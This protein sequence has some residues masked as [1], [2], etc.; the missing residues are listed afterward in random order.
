[1]RKTVLAVAAAV[2]APALVRADDPPPQ[3]P[4]KQDEP[5]SAQPELERE[6]V[7]VASRREEPAANAT[8]AISTFDEED[9]DRLRPISV[10]DV[11]REAPGTYVSA[12]GP[13]GQF[14]RVFLRGAASNQTLLLV[15]GIPQNDATAG[16]LFDFG[17]LTMTGVERVEVLRGSYSVLYGSE[18]IGGV[19]SVHT[20]RG[21]GAPSGYVTAQI[22][23]FGTRREEV[24]WSTGDEDFDM[25]FAVGDTAS[26]GDIDREEY[27]AHDAV[28]RFGVALG[29]SMRFDGSLRI[30]CTSVQSPYDFASSGV[31]P[32][33]DNIGR[34]AETYSGGGTLTWDATRDLTVRATVSG[35]NVE[36][37][38]DNGPDG[39]VLVDP[40]LTPGTG[41]E[42]TAFRDEL[43]S[44]NTATDLR[45]RIEATA[46]LLRRARQRIGLSLTGGGEHLNQRTISSST[47]PNFTAPGST[48]TRLNDTTR[49][50]SLFAQA[51][52]RAPQDAVGGEVVSN[53]AVT[54]GY[55]GDDHSEFGHEGSPYAGVRTEVFKMTVRASYGEGFRAPKPSELFDAFVGN[56]GLGAETSQSFDVGASRPFLDGALML[57]VTWFRLDVDGLIAYDATATS[58]TRPFG[59]LTNFSNTR[60]DGF[61][62]E[63]VAD[64]GRGFLVRGT[65]TTQN[66]RDRDTGLPLPNRARR[67][68]SA[69]IAYQWDRLLVSLDGFFSGEN[70]GETH[71]ITGPDEDAREHPGRRSLV[72]LSVRWRAT[73][74]LTVFGGVRNILDDEWVATASSPAGTGIGAYVGAQLDF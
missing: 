30:A 18:A 58:P 21:R 63:A 40:D 55:R 44:H 64:I 13:P 59:Q 31:L 2:V 8:S 25:A 47:S 61:E 65:Y 43:I 6:I 28:G 3:E 32:E 27:S 35:F 10:S 15:D 11:L 42:F 67:F 57:G 71:A 38:F 68:G 36:S 24:G 14:T 66:P 5:K 62:Y 12:D 29:E 52:L 23:S 49:N 19:V 45:G 26:D 20:R 9:F 39:V 72:D 4:P 1:V 46:T 33:D 34:R 54:A 22:G 60:T 69:G 74:S 37:N 41:D 51:E 17:G 73:E 56:T 7:V 16:G 53:G 70:G 50:N 48:T